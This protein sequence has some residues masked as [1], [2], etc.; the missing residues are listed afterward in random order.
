M[1]H[2]QFFHGLPQGAELIRALNRSGLGS[3]RQLLLEASNLIG[4]RLEP[5]SVVVYLS[6]PADLVGVVIRLGIL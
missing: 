1:I 5:P 6:A 4:R 2:G 3:L